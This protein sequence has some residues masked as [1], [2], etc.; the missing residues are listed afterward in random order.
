MKMLVV[1][2]V[3]MWEKGLG[4]HA[5]AKLLNSLESL[6]LR[7]GNQFSEITTAMSA[8]AEE[9]KKKCLSHWRRA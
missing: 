8:S 7:R 5:A 1:T 3:E 9:F 4:C 6:R 2:G